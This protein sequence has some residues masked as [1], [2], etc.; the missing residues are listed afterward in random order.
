MRHGDINLL[1]QLLAVNLIAGSALGAV[2]AA[3]FLAF[4]LDGLR[5]LVLAS[6]QEATALAMLF[7]GCASTFATAAVAGAV[8]MLATADDNDAGGGGVM[9]Q[10]AIN[11]EADGRAQFCERRRD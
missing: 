10:I 3:L 11:I 4:D 5:T 7:I 6:D 1:Y 2:L 9:R 8:M